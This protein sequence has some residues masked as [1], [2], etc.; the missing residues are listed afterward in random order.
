MAF[1]YLHLY[2]LFTFISLIIIFI[3]AIFMKRKNTYGEQILAKV[4]GFKN[5]LETA[6]KDQLN[7]LVND[8]PNYFYDILPYTY[9]L[10][11]SK[12]WIEKF[13][14]IPIPQ[15]DMGNF[16]YANID[17]FNILYAVH[18]VAEV[19]HHVEV[20]VLGKKICFTMAFK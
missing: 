20:V 16:D 1:L 10:G 5:Y 19:V 4:K 18:H 2:N 7:K 15:N 11:V 17:S 9:V 14:N 8:N 3:L 13:E 6:E 12:K